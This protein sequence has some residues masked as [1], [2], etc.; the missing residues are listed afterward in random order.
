M[1]QFWREG[2]WRLSVNGVRHWVSGHGVNRDSTASR[3]LG[4]AVKSPF[5]AEGAQR[6]EPD[7]R[8][9]LRFPCWICGELVWFVRPEQGGCFFCDERGGDW[10]PHAC[11]PRQEDPRRVPATPMPASSVQFVTRKVSTTEAAVMGV[12]PLS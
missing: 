5:A 8:R 9:S 6:R 7:E 1:T 12:W 11:F 2:F 4:G 3:S 10:P